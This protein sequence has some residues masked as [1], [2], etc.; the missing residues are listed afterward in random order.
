MPVNVAILAGGDSG[1]YQVSL[2][3]AGVVKRHIDPA[4]FR[5]FTVLVRGK[6]W[7]VIADDGRVFPVDKN[8]FSVQIDGETIAFDV[9]F[10]A[11]HGQPGEDGRMQGYLDMM[12]IPYTTCSHDT[13]AVCFNKKFASRIAHEAGMNVAR[14]I[15]LRKNETFDIHN[16][17]KELGLP[18]FVKPIR[19]GSSIGVSKVKRAEDL[20]P[21]LEKAF[22]ED[23]EAAVEEFL[24]G[25]ELTCGMLDSVGGMLVFPLTEVVPKNEFFDYEA[26]YTAGKSDEIT[27]A[28]VDEEVSAEVVKA[29]RILYHT[30]SCKGVVRFDFILTGKGLYFMEANTV[31]GLSEASIVPQQAQAMGLSIK[32]LFTLALEAAMAGK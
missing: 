8:V 14:S 28:P 23:S 15:Y 13:S 3:S 30:F 26:K 27:P 1:E 7:N 19:S 16:I 32:E 12:G 10:M 4:R 6:Q 18:C 20:L 22:A 24:P 25:R 11:I 21:A 31:P 17:T 9:A 29:S 5:A 2:N